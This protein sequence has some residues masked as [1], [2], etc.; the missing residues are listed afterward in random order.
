M[1]STRLKYKLTVFD[2]LQI[3]IRVRPYIEPVLQCYNCF[4]YG[5]VKAHCKRD[6]KCIVCGDKA[7]GEC[8]RR[9]EC[10]NC[11]REHKSTDRTCPVF[12]RIRELKVIMAYNNISFAEAE[13]LVSGKVE[14]EFRPQYDRYI[15]PSTWPEVRSAKSGGSSRPTEIELTKMA[16][17]VQR[18]W[19]A[20]EGESG[21][22]SF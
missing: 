17:E 19:R 21:A 1:R 7:H 13:R 10:C 4:M 18:G 20:E 6:V 11:G 2:N 5:H 16:R 8:L 14:D 9:L 3:K 22:R 15:N 12:Q